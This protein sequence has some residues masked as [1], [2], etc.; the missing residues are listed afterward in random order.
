M[1]R[2]KVLRVK[3]NILFSGLLLTLLIATCMSG[4]VCAQA[5]QTTVCELLA[6]PKSNVGKMVTLNATLVA[7]EEFSAFTD[8]SCQPRPSELDGKHP[9]IA[10]SFNKT[11]YRVGSS[12]DRKLSKVLK[13]ENQA[14]VTI[15]G[16]FIDPGHYFGHQLCCRYQLDV[17]DLLSVEQVKVVR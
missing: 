8:E 12:V 5:K 7:N 6:D 14:R 1:I 17:L 11:H 3:A 15:V 16:V 10:P 9:L 4:A 2:R 13:K